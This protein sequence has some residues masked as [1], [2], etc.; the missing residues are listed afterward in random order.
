KCIRPP[1]APVTAIVTAFKVRL[2]SRSIINHQ[3]YNKH[4]K[5]LLFNN[6]SI[7]LFL[8]IYQVNLRSHQ[9]YLPLKNSYF[10]D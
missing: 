3:I 2:L 8:I 10:Y 5:E 7:N 1:S 9:N 4:K 6:S